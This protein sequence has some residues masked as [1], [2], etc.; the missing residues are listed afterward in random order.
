MITT[1]LLNILYYFIVGI[2]SPIR[3]LPDV[4]LPEGLTSA[5]QTASGYFTSLNTI[6]PMDTM[7]TILGVSLA[8]EGLYI[9]YKLIMWVIKKVPGLN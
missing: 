1:A 7:I 8:F 4:S 2:T 5:I 6:L 9:I 3:A